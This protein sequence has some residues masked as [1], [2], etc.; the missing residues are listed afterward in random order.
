MT[1]RTGSVDEALSAAVL[2]RVDASSFPPEARSAVR[3]RGKDARRFCNGMFTNNVRDLPV[4]AWNRSAV[5]DDRAHVGGFLDLLCEADDTFLA[6][7]DGMTP[8]DFLER[9]EKFVIFDDVALE[10]PELTRLAVIGP[11]AASA[12]AAAGLPVPAPGAFAA[13]AEGARI[14]RHRRAPVESF[15]VLAPSSSPPVDL[16]EI[17]EEALEILRLLARVPHHPRDTEGKR[18]PHELDVRDEMLAFEKGCYVGQ[19]TIHRVDVMGQVR[20][21]L[22]RVELERP[23]AAGASL[24]VGG[25]DV[26]K[27]TSAAEHPPGRG[28]ALA[29]VRVPHDAPGTAVSTAEG[30]A[31]KVLP[32]PDPVRA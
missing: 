14:W 32:P 22:V 9:Y 30:V 7:L 5:V 16:P 17:G 18:L 31:G 25:A 26:G 3:L 23:V 2:A 8:A 27:V 10:V 6:V 12:L 1:T 15:E 13:T 4:G 20:R 24:T 21:K 19:E 11:K 28:V 29:L